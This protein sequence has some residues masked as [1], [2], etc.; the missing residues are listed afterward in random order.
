MSEARRATAAS[1]T[2][3]NFDKKKSMFWS[4]VCA[5]LVSSLLQTVDVA[6]CRWAV[7]PSLER[8]FRDAVRSMASRTLAL[9]TRFR[10]AAAPVSSEAA[11]LAA[12]GLVRAG[13]VLFGH[14]QAPANWS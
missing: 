13:D 12:V 4:F 11:P 5:V 1:P 9:P 8:G 2:S 6:A 7:Y 14:F 3:A 10:S